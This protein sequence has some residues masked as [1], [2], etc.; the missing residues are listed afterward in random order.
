MITTLTT[1]IN[2]QPEVNRVGSPLLNLKINV[3]SFFPLNLTGNTILS[4]AT[5][6]LDKPSKHNIDNG[7]FKFNGPIM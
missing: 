1:G 5:T 2:L 3:V 4:V 6:Q 7:N